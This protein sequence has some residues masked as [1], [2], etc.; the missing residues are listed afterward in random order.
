[1]DSHDPDGIRPTF[2]PQVTARTRQRVTQLVRRSANPPDRLAVE[3]IEWFIVICCLIGT[4]ASGLALAWLIGL[5]I[6][7]TATVF[8]HREMT[9]AGLKHYRDQFIVP[10][11][12]DAICQP[13][14]LRTRR[15]IDT[16]LGSEVHATGLLAGAAGETELKRHEW[17]IATQLRDITRLRAEHLSA[18]STRVPG[19]RTAAVLAS[20]R[21]AL[22]K[23][24]DAT[25]ERVTALERYAGQV[26]AADDAQ[27]DWRDALRAA[28]HNPRYLDLVARTAADQHAVAELTVLTDQIAAAEQAFHDSIHQAVVAAEVL[29]FLDEN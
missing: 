10:A 12:L 24:Q 5:A 22:T 8:V 26:K 13:F 1:M 7:V 29:A 25:A 19:P 3:R 2:N 17:E 14:M 20:H 27:Q 15:A 6:S 4:V 9:S 23:A 16:V 28:D 18:T 21:L 11:D